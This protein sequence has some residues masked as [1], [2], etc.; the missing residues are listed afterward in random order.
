MQFEGIYYSTD[1]S[2]SAGLNSYTNVQSQIFGKNGD[3]IKNL[4]PN[5]LYKI[6]INIWTT[7]DA[8]QM[9]AN[10]ID[11]LYPSRFSGHPLMYNF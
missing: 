1:D 4:G 11:G 2:C 5:L 8:T 6:V 7:N 3:G 9:T 10:T